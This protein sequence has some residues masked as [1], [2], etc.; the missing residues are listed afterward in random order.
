M[1]RVSSADDA[2]HGDPCVEI[3]AAPDGD[4]VIRNSNHPDGAHLTFTAEQIRA[5]FTGVRAREFDHL[6]E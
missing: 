3:G 2:R 4:I 6:L 1:W 5:F